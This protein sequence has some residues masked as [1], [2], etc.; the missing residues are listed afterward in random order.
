LLPARL[1]AVPDVQF[2]WVFRP[3]AV[4]GGD[5]L[6]IF[7][8]DDDHLGVYLLDVSGHGV[9][10]ALLS[11][12]LAHLLSP[13]LNPSSLLR[14]PQ[15]GGQAFRITRPA[16]VARQLN[17]WLLANPAGEKYF[18]IVYGIL[19]ARTRCF[20]YVSAGHPPLIH[21]PHDGEPVLLR[22]SG[23]PIGFF[24]E[25]Q[26]EET[27]LQLGAGDRLF[28]YSDGL[29][30]A[31]GPAGEQFGGTRLQR[32]IRAAKG[33]SLETCIQR[34]TSEVMHWAQNDL[35]D[36]LSVLALGIE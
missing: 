28:L 26:Y 10:A 1:P 29:T 5:G 12:T 32:A 7:S 14:A 19:N 30:E 21:A 17:E 20:R 18:T 16:E 34:V 6:N 35:K 36:D 8:L 13:G 31:T 24:P 23:Y 33:E 22:V 15:P 11:V 2:G 25:A 9:A 27:E 3:S 4:L